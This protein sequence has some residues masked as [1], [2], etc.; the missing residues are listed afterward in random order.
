MISDKARRNRW[1][2]YIKDIKDCY[3]KMGG[4]YA[5]VSAH[6]PR[7]ELIERFIGRFLEDESFDMLCRYMESG[8]R[9]EAFRAAHT[10]KGV[11]ANLGFA[12]L[13]DSSSRLTEVLRAEAGSISESALAILDDV[14][15]DY[16]LTT[17]TI[18]GYF[19]RS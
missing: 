4:D 5:A 18:H 17:D 16:D 6:L 12:R 15:R 9:K 11:C 2:M 10:L 19:D 8:N 1:T 3:E 7:Q 14:K 13:F